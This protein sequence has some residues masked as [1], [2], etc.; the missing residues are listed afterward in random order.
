MK[1]IVFNG[2][3]DCGKDEALLYLKRQYGVYGFSFKSHLKK[4][5]LELY[6]IPEALWDSWYTRDGKELPREEL[7]GL[8]QRQALIQV[9]EMIVKPNFGKDYF[10]RAE[11]KKII[12]AQQDNPNLICACSDGGFNEEITPLIEYFTSSNIN[13]VYI[14]RPNRSFT[15]DSRNWIDVPDIPKENYYLIENDSGLEKYWEK[16]DSIYNFIV[17]Q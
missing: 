15:N 13:I 9:S 14:K 17:K 3:P 4:L 16:I 6:Q 10:G 12:T 11:A 2:P 1:I 5:T 8:S 7:N